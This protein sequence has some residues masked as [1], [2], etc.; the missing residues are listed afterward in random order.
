MMDDS[1]SLESGVPEVAVEQE[2]MVNISPE[3]LTFLAEEPPDGKNHQRKKSP[4]VEFNDDRGVK[5]NLAANLKLIRE[6]LAAIENKKLV[7]GT[8]PI[9]EEPIKIAVRQV[10]YEWAKGKKA[11]NI[12]K[13]INDA[14]EAFQRLAAYMENSKTPLGEGDIHLLEE[15]LNEFIPTSPRAVVNNVRKRFNGCVREIVVRGEE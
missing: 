15:V 14:I 13:A 2:N 6:F 12:R 11:N 9:D 5:K 8:I 3:D 1:L 7:G 10:A 4:S